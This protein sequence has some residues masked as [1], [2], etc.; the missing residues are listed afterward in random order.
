[1][2]MKLSDYEQGIKEANESIKYLKRRYKGDELKQKLNYCH[3]YHDSQQFR[4]LK[5][6]KTKNSDLHRGKAM[7]YGYYYSTGKKLKSNYLRKKRKK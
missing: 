3:E 2:S 5:N 4:Y 6:G 7:A 1:M